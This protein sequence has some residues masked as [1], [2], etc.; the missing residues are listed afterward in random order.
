MSLTME[1]DSATEE[2]LNDRARELCTDPER[3]AAL[4]LA[5]A[6]RALPAS[7]DDVIPEAEL[8]ELLEGVR[9][10]DA[11]FADGKYRSLDEV[12]E[13]KNRRFGLDIKL[14]K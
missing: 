14:N 11:A 9:R 2:M 3:L 10:G 7:Y 5:D 1:L 8:A 4:M 6:L 12:V 13:D